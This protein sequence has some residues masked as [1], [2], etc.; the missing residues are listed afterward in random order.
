MSLK[1]I[2]D[3]K[4]KILDSLEQESNI[5]R[6]MG[7]ESYNNHN[8]TQVPVYFIDERLQG[9]IDFLSKDKKRFLD[10]EKAKYDYIRFCINESRKRILKY[11]LK[12]KK[13]NSNIYGNEK[14]RI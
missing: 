8:I 3:R 4:K 9:F 1:Y 6:K 11:N 5:V 7:S 10:L 14:Q 2:K 13:T 12:N